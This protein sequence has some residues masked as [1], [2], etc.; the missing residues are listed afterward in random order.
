MTQH[1]IC[2]GCL[3][4][5]SAGVKTLDCCGNNTVD[6]DNVADSR[7]LDA[8]G[9]LLLLLNAAF[10]LLMVGLIL[11]AARHDIMMQVSWVWE[12]TQRA[13]YRSTE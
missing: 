2:C 8:V 10:V 12:H 7:G 3:V 6:T 5:L 13:L 11:L 4:C 1:I 9:V